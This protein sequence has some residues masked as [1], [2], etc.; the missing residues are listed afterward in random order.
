MTNPELSIVQYGFILKSDQLSHG[1][2]AVK[3]APVSKV[4]TPKTYSIEVRFSK[5]KSLC[6]VFRKVQVRHGLGGMVSYAGLVPL[7]LGLVRS[8][9]N[10][11]WSLNHFHVDSASSALLRKLCFRSDALGPTRLPVSTHTSSGTAHV[12]LVLAL[13]HPLCP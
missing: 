1:I 10:P 8:I 12:A 7:P 13:K 9:R 4:C 5:S 3:R 11:M 6:N 2:V